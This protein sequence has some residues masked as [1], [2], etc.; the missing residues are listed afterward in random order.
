MRSI[1]L[2][3][4]II[5]AFAAVFGV[6]FYL[7]VFSPGFS[8]SDD[9]DSREVVVDKGNRDD[10]LAKDRQI[11]ALLHK[12]RGLEKEV[13]DLK[14][15]LR[16]AKPDPAPLATTAEL[17]DRKVV[18]TRVFSVQSGDCFDV[19][20][21]MTCFYAKVHIDDDT[22]GYIIYKAN[23]AFSNDDES[24]VLF[25]DSGDRLS[26]LTPKDAEAIRVWERQYPNLYQSLFNY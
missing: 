13:Q 5:F 11:D 2:T 15:E 7:E 4:S 19:N 1:F 16:V 23:R 21:Y 12:N 8:I 20:G 25:N 6:L 10:V 17:N 9:Q 26:L 24:L 14:E 22:I 3:A 18:I